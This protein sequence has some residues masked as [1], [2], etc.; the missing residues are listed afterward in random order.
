MRETGMTSF[1]LVKVAGAW[2][3]ESWTWASPKAVVAK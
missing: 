1:V 3:V 2:K